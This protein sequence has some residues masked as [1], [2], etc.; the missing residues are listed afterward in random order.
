MSQK[1]EFVERGGRFAKRTLHSGRMKGKNLRYWQERRNKGTM[2]VLGTPCV[3]MKTPQA[4][5]L[6]NLSELFRRSPNVSPLERVSAKLE[7][8]VRFESFDDKS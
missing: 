7:Q 3:P 5:Q 1:K 4:N 2:K 6:W 8:D